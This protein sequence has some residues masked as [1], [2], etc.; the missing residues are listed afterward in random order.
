ENQIDDD[1]VY[2]P[3]SKQAVGVY[4]LGF[5]SCTGG[6]FAYSTLAQSYREFLKYLSTWKCMFHAISIT[7][8]ISLYSRFVRFI[9]CAYH[10]NR[11][12]TLTR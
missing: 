5:F 11:E 2:M 6:P 8:I 10:S 12:L 1:D 9:I 4:Q 7:W 3:F